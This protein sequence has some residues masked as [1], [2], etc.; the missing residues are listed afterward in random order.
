M[1]QVRAKF[2][3]LSITNKWDKTI[4]AEL[5][6]VMNRKSE[7]FEENKKFWQASPSGECHLTFHKEH[8]L[9][10]GAYYYLDMVQDDEGDWTLN[11]VCNRGNGSGEV[12]FSY[13][14][15]YDWQNKPVGMLD[16]HF[17]IGIDGHHTDALAAFGEPEKK[18]KVTFTLAEESD[19]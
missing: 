1:R 7:N 11:E 14:R 2:R 17:K 16:G 4:L 8:G 13:Y 10:L 9:E 18:W 5:H 15:N 19:D 3:C 12:F 6:P